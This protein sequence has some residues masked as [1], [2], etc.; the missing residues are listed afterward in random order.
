MLL[1]RSRAMRRSWHF[2]CVWEPSQGSKWFQKAWLGFVRI[3]ALTP[4]FSHSISHFTR[5]THPC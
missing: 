2:L 5:F 1:K 4:F 3:R